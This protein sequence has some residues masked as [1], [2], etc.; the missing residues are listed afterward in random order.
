V[1]KTG[2]YVAPTGK[3]ITGSVFDGNK[4]RIERQLKF[5]DKQLYIKWNPKK[6]GGWGCWEVRRKPEFLSSVYQGTLNGTAY[7]TA[8]YKETDIVHHVLDVPVLTDKLLGKI[9][10]MDTW[11]HKDWVG[12]MEYEGA[13]YKE[14]IE[15]GAREELKYEITQHKREWREL[16]SLVQQG[17]NLGQF[18]KGIRG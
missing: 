5:Y 14:R 9:K 4:A 12:H 15:A 7:Y 17:A 3:L 18:L 6:R 10:S 13:K 16:A 1:L 8:E 2:D 11:N